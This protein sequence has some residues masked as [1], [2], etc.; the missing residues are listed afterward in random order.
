MGRGAWI[1]V[2][3]HGDTMLKRALPFGGLLGSSEFRQH[4]STDSVPLGEAHVKGSGKAH[5]KGSGKSCNKDFTSHTS[6]KDPCL[7]S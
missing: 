5:V 3:I 7:M 4:C 2:C 1:A 6:S